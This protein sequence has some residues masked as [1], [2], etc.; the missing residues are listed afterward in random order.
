MRGIAAL[1]ATIGEG[2]RL[3][4]L[5]S[6]DGDDAIA[7]RELLV[8]REIHQAA[9]ALAAD[10]VVVRGL[11]ADD[12]AQRNEAVIAAGRECNGTRNLE[13]ARDDHALQRRAIL[14]DLAL[15]AG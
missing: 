2:T 5:H 9:R 4:L 7:D 1:V 12:A 15:G 13:G 14:L 11:A 6:V 10:I 8:H 3:G